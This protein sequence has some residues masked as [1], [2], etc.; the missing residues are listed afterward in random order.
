M[1]TPHPPA[2]A[3]ELS[4]DVVDVFAERPFAGNQLAVVHGAGDLE[5]AGMLALAR[6]FGYSETTFPV[7]LAADR[8][9]VRI[10]TPGGEVPFAGHPTLGTAWVLARRGELSAREAVQECAAGAIAVRLE[11]D[12]V[13]LAAVPRDLIGPLPEA[14]VDALADA[15]GLCGADVAGETWI[16]G[17]GLSFVHLPV[18]PGAVARAVVPRR[19]VRESA[20]LPPTGD[21][22]DGIAIHAVTGEPTERGETA[23]HCRVFVPGLSVPEDPATGSAATGLGMVLYRRGVLGGSRGLRYRVGQGRELGRP[24]VLLGR[25]E[26]GPGT[27]ATGLVELVRVSGAVHPIARGTIRV[28]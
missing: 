21:P 23:V 6:E 9:R 28:P 2:T 27:D 18:R 10:F 17:T 14:A 26:A 19:P 13:E 1:R 16:A 20:Q 22:L 4:Y 25:V 5:D 24:S 15:V 3:G 11:A 8:Y 7:P 12:R